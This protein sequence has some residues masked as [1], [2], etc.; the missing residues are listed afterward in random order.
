M[1]VQHKVSVYDSDFGN[2]TTSY[3]ARS[4]QLV[5]SHTMLLIDYSSLAHAFDLPGRNLFS[6]AVAASS[7]VL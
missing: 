4:Y 6:V 3:L 5:P 2:Y 1:V 7:G